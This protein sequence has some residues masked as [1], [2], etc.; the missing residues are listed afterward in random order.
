MTPRAVLLGVVPGPAASAPA[1]PGNLSEMY[2]LRP[3]SDL[4]NQKL[5][6][7]GPQ[8]GF[9]RVLQEILVHVRV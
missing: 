5:W 3:A 1:S 9:Y 2:T 4:L 8:S 6:V 7:W